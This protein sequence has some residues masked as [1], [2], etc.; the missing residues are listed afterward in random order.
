MANGDIQMSKK[1]RRALE[2]V[3]SSLDERYQP[4]VVSS[5]DGAKVLKELDLTIEKYNNLSNRSNNFIGD[6]ASALNAERK[7]SSSQYATFE[8]KNG[9]IVTIRLANHN[10]KVSTFDKRGEDD[11]I[12]I[13]ITANKNVRITN[14]GN[15]HIVGMYG[16]FLT[17]GN[18]RVNW[19]V[20][21]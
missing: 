8:T 18:R 10:A 7:G 2:T 6:V 15:A 16:Q 11:G 3:S 1:K 21:I 17:K 5:A 9:K 20:Q 12:S 4:T 14:D 19:Q 13:V